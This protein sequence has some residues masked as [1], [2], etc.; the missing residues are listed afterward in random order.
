VRIVF[1]SVD[2]AGDAVFD[3]CR[4][5]VDEQAKT[6]VSQPEIGEKLLLV[7]RGEHLDGFDFDDD[8]VF[9]DQVG[10]ESGIY[11]DLLI[12]HRN[13]LLTDRAEAPPAQFVRQDCIVNGLQQ[14]R[15][16][17]GMNAESGVDDLL[18]DGVLVMVALLSFSPRR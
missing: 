11:A 5:K 10:T 14:A 9:D 7:D 12:D 4:V 3:Q 8:P 17:R 13:R 2:H 15:A 1:E 18:G 6:L 16:E